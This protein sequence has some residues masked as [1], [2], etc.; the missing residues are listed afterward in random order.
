M[1]SI[2]RDPRAVPGPIP[3]TFTIGDQHTI[4]HRVM[5]DRTTGFVTQK[6]I[7]A[8]PEEILEREIASHRRALEGVEFRLAHVAEPL[9]WYEAAPSEQ[10]VERRRQALGAERAHVLAKLVELGQRNPSP[11]GS[12]DFE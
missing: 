7:T 10:E 9:A 4:D 6:P 3:N 8:T 2:I 5:V 11:G 1:P 12:V